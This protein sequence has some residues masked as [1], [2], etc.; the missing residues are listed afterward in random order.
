MKQRLIVRELFDGKQ[1]RRHQVVEVQDGVITCCETVSAD[2]PEMLDG[3]LVPG[4]IDA[5]V[6]GGGGVLFNH[7]PTVHTLQTMAQAHSSFGTTAMLPTLITD[8]IKVIEQAAQAVADAIAEKVPGILGIHFEGPHLSTP[9]KG[10]HEA[11]HIRGI[12]E[13]EWA[14]Y[15]RD[16]LGVKLMTIAPE[17]VT[18]SEVCALR[19]MG[20]IVCIGHSNA[21]F[22]TTRAALAAG[23]KGFTHLFNAMSPMTSR[24]PGVVGA[25]LSDTQSWCGLIVDGQHVHPA[26]LQVACTAKPEEKT[27]LV[28][29]AMSF[30]GSDANQMMLGDKVVQREAGKLTTS[31]GTLA[32]SDLTMDQAIR[33]T[34]SLLNFP[35]ERALNMGSRYVAEFLQLQNEYGL[36]QPGMQAN[37]VLLDEKTLTLKQV[38]QAGNMILNHSK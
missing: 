1:R 3:L 27:F 33:N 24:E 34:C 16:D 18:P 17:T 19:D 4:W 14:I 31:D 38:W 29:D 6:N 15:R 25:A 32:G 35:L 10:V 13:A 20:V 9:K 2:H 5:Q 26:T 37:M 8:D 22:E 36:I 30:A 21:G 28:T 7:A 12:S 11:S 23:A